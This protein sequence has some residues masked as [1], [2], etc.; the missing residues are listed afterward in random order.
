MDHKSAKTEIHTVCKSP[1][2]SPL[3]QK[4]C[5][6]NFYIPAKG[7]RETYTAIFQMGVCAWCHYGHTISTLSEAVQEFSTFHAHPWFLVGGNTGWQGVFS[8]RGHSETCH[9]SQKISSDDHSK[10]E[11]LGG[12]QTRKNILSPRSDTHPFLSWFFDQNSS[13]GLHSCEGAGNSVPQVLGKGELD[14]SELL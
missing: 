8:S 14:A 1:A 9:I 13:H 2:Y 5:A 3:F 6:L 11:G 12:S 7:E 4:L 10:E